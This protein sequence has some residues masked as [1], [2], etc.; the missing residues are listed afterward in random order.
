[1]I[2][3][4]TAFLWRN[5]GVVPA[6]TR[7][8]AACFAA[9]TVREFARGKFA[10]RDAVAGARNHGRQ[11]KKEA[12]FKRASPKIARKKKAAESAGTVAEKLLGSRLE[13]EFVPLEFVNLMVPL[14]KNRQAIAKNPGLKMVELCPALRASRG[15][16]PIAFAASGG[17]SYG[18]TPRA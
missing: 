5:S 2:R 18:P 13:P 4:K 15:R 3:Q 17:N 16:W 6:Q 14:R 1:V 11:K 8:A 9:G 7:V 12:S 10:S